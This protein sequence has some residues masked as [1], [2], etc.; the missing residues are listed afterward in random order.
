MDIDLLTL[1][2]GN[3][4]LG[5]ALFK[6]GE[7]VYTRRATVG[8]RDDWRGMIAEAWD[9]LDENRR[10]AA[11]VAGAASN[12]MLVEP[13]E[14]AAKKATGRRVE[15]AGSDLDLPIKVAT[16][17]PTKT[18]ID[19]VLNV[20]AA[21]E[22]IGRA[23]CVVDAGTAV[24][25]DFCDDEGT[26]LGGAIAPGL[27]VQLQ[28]LRDATGGR[29]PEV[30]AAVPDGLVGTDT[31]Q[32]MRHGVWHGVRGLVQQVVERY[33]LS[34]NAWPDVV[35]TG[36]DAKLLFDGWELIHALSPDLTHYGIAAAYAEHHIARGT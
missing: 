19:R 23:C 36:G 27:R 16:D 35:A 12:P 9:H 11:G 20:A 26:F 24:T 10:E 1:D 14:F 4:R 29:L 2:L 7:L 21:Y 6:A 17:E 3:S 32:A 18:G 22:Q 33:A 30:A 34:G 25:I 28:S 8:Q 13:L 15:W 5:I 31:E